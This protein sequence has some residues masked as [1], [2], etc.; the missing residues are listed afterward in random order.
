[1]INSNNNLGD[2]CKEL[3]NKL[4]NKPD[5]LKNLFKMTTFNVFGEMFFDFFDPE[6]HQPW[7]CDPVTMRDGGGLCQDYVSV[8]NKLFFV[9]LCL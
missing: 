9:F 2:T 4:Y 6:E 5:I 1:M 7:T 3:D 8:L